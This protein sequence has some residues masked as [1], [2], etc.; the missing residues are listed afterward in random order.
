MAATTTA[1]RKRAHAAK[2]SRPVRRAGRSTRRENDPV[3]R[4]LMNAPFDDEPVTPEEE[5]L[6]QE[7]RD[8]FK[9]GEV[10]SDDELWRRLGHEPRR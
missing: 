4:A 10:I 3:V 7:G 9:R 8:A 6:V 2:P 5:A 1:S